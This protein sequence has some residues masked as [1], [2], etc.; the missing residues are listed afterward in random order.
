MAG[1][2][3]FGGVVTMVSGASTSTPL[4]L[5]TGWNVLLV[6]VST[7]STAAAISVQNSL[8][9]GTTYYN[10]FQPSINSATVATPQYFIASGV[11]TNGGITQIPIAGL[12]QIQF[13]A[14][15]V[16]SGGVIFK[17]HAV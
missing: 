4:D 2:G 15:A 13:L 12:R 11:G 5:N 1:Y 9:G 7:M 16:V 10:V 14:T 6:Q 17:I 3:K 8:D